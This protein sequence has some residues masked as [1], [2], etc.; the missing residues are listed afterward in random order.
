MFLSPNPETRKTNA[1]TII[2]SFSDH[3]KHDKHN[4]KKP[5]LTPHACF[6]EHDITSPSNAQQNPAKFP[7]H[8]QPRITDPYHRSNSAASRVAKLKVSVQD[9]S[10]KGSTTTDTENHGFREDPQVPS[11]RKQRRASSKDISK[12]GQG[13]TGRWMGRKG[14]EAVGQVSV[15]R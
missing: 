15:R 8:V 1:Q 14:E 9:G 12:A 4:K 6:Y 5:R 2:T 10:Q 7:V 13:S 11:T 3:P